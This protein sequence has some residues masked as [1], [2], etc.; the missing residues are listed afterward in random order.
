MSVKF[1]LDLMYGLRD[2]LDIAKLVSKYFKVKFELNL[3]C[4]SHLLRKFRKT[5]FINSS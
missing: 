1:Q 5:F 2:M 4:I 3:V